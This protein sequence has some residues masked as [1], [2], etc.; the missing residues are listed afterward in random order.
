MP[1]VTT[2]RIT[3]EVTIEHGNAKIQA[4]IFSDGSVSL[5]PKNNRA[6]FEFKNSDV[7]LVS[8]IT[9]C[10]I[11]S[12]ELSKDLQKEFSEYTTEEATD[13]GK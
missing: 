10:F 4:E 3:Q 7:A 5:K 2:K 9:Q 11:K 13:G 12:V 6:M 8:D 1:K